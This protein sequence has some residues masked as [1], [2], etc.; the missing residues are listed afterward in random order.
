MDSKPK[1]L[2]R[3]LLFVLVPSVLVLGACGLY[4]NN[5]FFKTTSRKADLTAFKAKLADKL[6]RSNPNEAA[7]SSISQNT[8]KA[9]APQKLVEQKTDAVRKQVGSS[10]DYLTRSDF[11]SFDEQAYA[12]AHYPYEAMQNPNLREE[13]W[14]NYVNNHPYTKVA[15]VDYK[16]IKQLP[17]YDRPDM[18][19]LH[20]KMR[21]LDPS[22][23]IAP[24]QRRF[25]AMEESQEQ[26]ALYGALPGVVWNERGPNNIGGRTRGIMWDPND[27]TARKLWAGGVGGGLW[28]NNDVTSAA[29]SWTKVND[30]WDNIAVTAIA[31]DP[32]NTNIFYVGTGEGFFNGDAQRGGGIWKTT[33][34]GVTWNRLGATTVA[35]FAYVNDLAVTSAGI[36][37]AATNNGLR[38]STDGGI[39]WAVPVGAPAGI[40]YDLEI[41]AAGTIIVARNNGTIHR[42]TD[43]SGAA[44]GAAIAPAAGGGRVE[45]ACAPSDANIVYA[46]AENTGTGDVQWFR[47]SADG[48][49]TWPTAV[50]IPMYLEQGVCAAAGNHFTRGQSWYDLILQVSP[51]NPNLV[52]AGGIDIHRS[53]DGGVTWN[54]VSYWTGAC[55]T[56][57][58][59]DQHAMAFRPGFPNQCAFGNDGGIHFSNNVGSAATPVPAFVERNLDYN[60][61]QYYACAIRNDAGG[62]YFL[63]GAQDNGSHQFNAAGINAITEVT[64]GDGAFCHIDQDNSLFQITSYVQN[65][66]Y[67]S[68]NGGVSF[69]NLVGAGGGRFINPTDYDDTGNILYCAQ[70]TNTLY[71]I[72][73]IT[74]VPAG[75]SNVATGAIGTTPTAVTVSPHTANR[76]FVA[77]SNGNIRRL[78]NANVGVAPAS[79]DVDPSNTLPNGY[80]N[81]I[82]LGPN[83]NHI[84]VT[85]AN[86]G[87][88]KVYLTTDG[89]V[90]WTNKTGDLP[91]MP[92]Y[93][94]QM[95]PLNHNQVLLATEVGVWSIDDISVAV[96]D[97]GPSST[98]L[99][100][101]RCDMLQLRAADNLVAVATH[102]RGLF[103]AT[104]FTVVPLSLDWVSFTG[105]RQD[106]DNLLEWV[107]TNEK[108]SHS[109]EIQRSANGSPDNFEVIGKVEAKG[110]QKATS[111]Q[112]VD[113][114]PPHTIAYYRIQETDL[115]GKKQL[116]KTIVIAREAEFG[117]TRLS[118][119]PIQSVGNLEYIVSQTGVVQ[120]SLLDAQG[121]V[122]QQ[123]NM[124]A[125]VGL[126]TWT[127]DA[128]ALTSG[129]YTVVI[130]QGKFKDSIRMVK[131]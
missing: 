100:N 113:T 18:L 6:S 4:L 26:L 128:S 62:N 118:P 115:D 68:I 15:Q 103:T 19:M 55:R 41:T 116:S 14:T 97:W 39:N 106:Q 75:T 107:T 99:A 51:V 93:W 5:S 76:V 64:G 131:Q 8:Q 12:A 44:F 10:V 52:L 125:Q 29:S 67:R 112:F 83:D 24:T 42:S 101:T 88:N 58:H 31:H 90:T 127:I 3:L 16:L 119:N 49:V 60:V 102:G 122:L 37:L 27:G 87:G 54:S 109:F 70:G 71:R 50:T 43:A 59:A 7:S 84:I 121:R 2:F 92:I 35:A 34:G 22:T 98:G 1:L 38:R 45:V 47:R 96:P 40:T 129:T 53:L 85:Y 94:A 61:T 91:D 82:A 81:S 72:N 48:G 56:Y 111:Y 30:F 32:L 108:G 73:N 114:N 124:Q 77:G 130:S 126:N 21:W 80:I 105:K 28:F 65:N 79:A 25:K 78:D 69:A 20:D 86:Y 104:P 95:N 66:Y 33:D 11:E 74:G 117:I 89:G 36:V 120:I 9:S 63:A 110:G 46:V 13:A 17:K 23:G 123:I 57:V